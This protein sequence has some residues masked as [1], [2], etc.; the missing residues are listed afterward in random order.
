MIRSYRQTTR[1]TGE[2]PAV[3]QRQLLIFQWTSLLKT[4]DNG[5]QNNFCI[6]QKYEKTLALMSYV[7]SYTRYKPVLAVAAMPESDE[8]VAAPIGK[9][10]EGITA[11]T[12]DGPHR[13][14]SVDVLIDQQLR[15]AFSK[16]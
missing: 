12:L 9:R 3:S 2:Q 6:G 10:A 13:R 15:D 5:P 16:F 1:V 14:N 8:R 11:I 7:N 4:F